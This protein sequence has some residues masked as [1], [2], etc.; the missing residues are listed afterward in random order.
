MHGSARVDLND[1]GSLIGWLA[2]QWWVWVIVGVVVLLILVVWLMPAAKV[3]PSEQYSTDDREANEI[4]LGFLQIA[5]FQGLQATRE[6]RG[7]LLSG[8]L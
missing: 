3:K 4:A 1:I 7:L 8:H 2:A 6:H 5:L